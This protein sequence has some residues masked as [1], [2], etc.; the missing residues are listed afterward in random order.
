[1]A[2]WGQPAMLHLEQQAA[3]GIQEAV[4]TEREAGRRETKWEQALSAG[5]VGKAGTA[6]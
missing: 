1:M 5:R 6:S 4:E 3:L 2:W